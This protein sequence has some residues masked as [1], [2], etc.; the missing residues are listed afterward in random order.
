[1]IYREA[2]V[3]EIPLITQSTLFIM[4]ADD[5]D[6]PGR[7]TAPEALRTEM[8]ENAEHAGRLAAE[9]PHGRAEVIAD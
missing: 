9:M 3:H 7:P 1:M 4:G 8:D 6:A 5:H 2:V